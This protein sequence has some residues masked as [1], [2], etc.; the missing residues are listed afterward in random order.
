MVAL[1][2]PGEFISGVK[3]PITINWKPLL[4]RVFSISKPNK[5]A[6]ERTRTADLLITSEP[7]GV[8]W[9]CT[10][11][12]IPHSYGVFSTPGCCVLHCIALPVVSEWCQV[13]VDNVGPVPLCARCTRRAVG[14]WRSPARWNLSCR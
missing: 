8:A 10:K 3:R 2:P 14:A 9:V 7:M 5:G 6:D 11:L 4:L 13:F 1:Y 12:Q